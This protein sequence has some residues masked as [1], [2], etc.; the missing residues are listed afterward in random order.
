MNCPN[1]KNPT[2]NNTAECEWCGAGFSIIPKDYEK[3][4]SNQSSISILFAW[5][6]MFTGVL[7]T[8]IAFY[9]IQIVHNYDSNDLYLGAL[10]FPLGL[11]IKIISKNEK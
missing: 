4:S 8:T 7:L 6:L 2:Q 10:L 3:N 9:R 11:F 1:C 5:L